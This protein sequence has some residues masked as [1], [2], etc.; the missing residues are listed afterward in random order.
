MSKLTGITR[1][2]KMNSPV[3]IRINSLRYKNRIII[4]VLCIP[5]YISLSNVSSS[6]LMSTLIRI[7]TGKRQQASSVISIIT[8]TED[9]KFICFFGFQIFKVDTSLFRSVIF[10]NKKI[11]LS[12]RINS[13]ISQKFGIRFQ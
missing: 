1:Q 13:K 5:G 7:C 4:L 6:H 9:I 11:I 12:R 8:T 10:F 2:F 3:N